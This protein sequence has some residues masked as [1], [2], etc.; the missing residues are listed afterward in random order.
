M[1]DTI[2]TPDAAVHRLLDALAITVTR[3]DH[4]AVFTVDEAEQH[5]AGIDATHCKNLFLRNRKGTRHYLVVAEHR[6]S[7]SLAR[8]A[9]IV[10]DDKLGFASPERLA[11]Y[12]GLTPGAVSPFGLI[13]DTAREV[14]VVVDVSLRAAS[15]VAFHPNVNTAT[16]VLAEPDF[17]RFLASTGHAVTWAQLA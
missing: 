4:P 8:I 15:L 13:N 12:L 5:W 1:S 2:E 14:R 17:E 10:G 9:A 7:V 16:L 11:K 3:Y 6:A